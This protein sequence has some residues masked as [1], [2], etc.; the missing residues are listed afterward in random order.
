[1]IVIGKDEVV[2]SH[3]ET[4]DRWGVGLPL[5]LVSV[6]E[7]VSMVGVKGFGCTFI[8]LRTNSPIFQLEFNYH[9]LKVKIVKKTKT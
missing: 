5:R 4:V 2:E 7:I 3:V 1:M 8:Y 9:K 6:H